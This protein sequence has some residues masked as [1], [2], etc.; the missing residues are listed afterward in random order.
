MRKSVRELLEC[1]SPLPLF[2]VRDFIG[3][4]TQ[5]SWELSHSLRQLLR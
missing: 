3:I 4:V 1:G 2:A 5:L